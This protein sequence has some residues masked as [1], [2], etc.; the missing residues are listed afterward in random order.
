MPILYCPILP[1]VYLWRPSCASQHKPDTYMIA[2]LI[3]APMLQIPSTRHCTHTGMQSLHW[4]IT[5][6]VTF[7]PLTLTMIP[8][9]DGQAYHK[10]LTSTMPR[11]SIIANYISNKPEQRLSLFGYNRLASR[12]HAHIMIT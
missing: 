12:L 11:T 7:S 8:L 5:E 3:T 6:T 2:S 10:S 4:I 9:F 1:W